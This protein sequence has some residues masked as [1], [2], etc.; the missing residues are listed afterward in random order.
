MQLINGVNVA[1][2][3]KKQRLA[4]A[5][6][7]T[8]KSLEQ[9]KRRGPTE[10][11][12]PQVPQSYLKAARREPKVGGNTKVRTT[13]ASSTSEKSEKTRSARSL[14]PL[15]N[16]QDETDYDALYEGFDTGYNQG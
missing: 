5:R 7:N 8:M 11:K 2:N 13:D 6:A 12:P 9:S 4:N 3:S 14:P 15:P 16:Y 1:H 10:N